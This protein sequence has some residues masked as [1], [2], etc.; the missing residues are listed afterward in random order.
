MHGL[1]H[2]APQLMSSRARSWVPEAL[3]RVVLETDT[4]TAERRGV[5]AAS[6]GLPSLPF[7]WPQFT[8]LHS[9][10]DLSPQLQVPTPSVAK[11]S[12][13]R[14]FLSL[15]QFCLKSQVQVL[16]VHSRSCDS[17]KSILEAPIGWTSWSCDPLERPKMA[18]PCT[19]V[20]GPCGP[21]GPDVVPVWSRVS[22]S[23]SV[24][25]KGESPTC[26]TSRVP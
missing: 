20:R 21:C 19:L 1:P 22:R 25:Q 16:L 14:G 15:T 17:S 7:S 6:S 9:Q 24:A 10:K 11:S 5:S 23:P 3:A 2:K 8:H 4:D 12:Q 18:P 13:V 26:P